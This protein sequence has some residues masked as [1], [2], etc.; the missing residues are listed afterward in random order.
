[1]T[2]IVAEKAGIR[3]L[4]HGL[5]RNVPIKVDACNFRKFMTSHK[6]SPDEIV[7]LWELVYT[8]PPKPCNQPKPKTPIPAKKKT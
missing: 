3:R 7:K 5:M 1:M 4:N 8:Q 6:H 2:G